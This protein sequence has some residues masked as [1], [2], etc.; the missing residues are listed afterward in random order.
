MFLSEPWKHIGNYSKAR[1]KLDDVPSILARIDA[2]LEKGGRTLD[3]GTFVDSERLTKIRDTVQGKQ[4]ELEATIANFPML[5][6]KD[7][8]LLLGVPSALLA[9][10]AAV[11]WVI[12]GFRRSNNSLS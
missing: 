3:D 5:V 1:D 6:L 2:D 7:V 12:G 9:L 8:L 4:T 11:A 10:G